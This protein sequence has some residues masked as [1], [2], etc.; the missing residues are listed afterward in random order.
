LPDKRSGSR[1]AVDSYLACMCSQFG[2]E[3]GNSG[4]SLAC[5]R[6]ISSTSWLTR[7]RT[8][9]FE[10]MHAALCVVCTGSREDVV[11]AD[12]R[13]MDGSEVHSGPLPCRRRQYRA[14][15]CDE[16]LASAC[17]STSLLIYA[18]QYFA[19]PAPSADPTTHT[20]DWLCFENRT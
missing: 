8:S 16:D 11:L 6:L 18:L 14:A 13:G 1:S 5:R 4:G 20:F 12:G 15:A 17:D 7:I 9:R 19:L 3:L 2:A 10:P